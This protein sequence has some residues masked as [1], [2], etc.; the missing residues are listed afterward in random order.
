MLDNCEHV[1]TG[2]APLA[3]ALLANA[4][5]MQVRRRHA[6]C[7]LSHLTEAERAWDSSNTEEWLAR[8]AMLIPDV[9]R[10][11]DWAENHASEAQTG[12]AI[13]AVMARL[14]RE[15]SLRVEG[16]QRIERALRIAGPDTPALIRGQ[17]L[18]G[19]AL[20]RVDN[21]PEI[22]IT[23]LEEAACIYRL[24]GD[25][26]RLTNPMLFLGIE[27][28]KR[29]DIAGAERA[30]EKCRLLLDASAS[31]R[32][33]IFGLELESVIHFYYHRFDEARE[34]L[35]QPLQVYEARGA[36]R[37]IFVTRGNMLEITLVSGDIGAA[38][39]EGLDLARR[40]HGTPHRGVFG[41]ISINRVA[42]LVR[43]RQFAAALAVAR[44]AAP[45]LPGFRPLFVLIDH[46]ALG[47]GLGGNSK[48]GAI[49]KGFTDCAYAARGWQRK[50]VEAFAATQLGTVLDESLAPDKLAGLVKRGAMLTEAAAWSLALIAI[51]AR[52]EVM[53]VAEV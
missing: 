39:T 25:R 8:Y 11:L 31:Q 48:D 38:I 9:H 49:L 2:V 21:E 46:L 23:A 5:K 4:P 37:S 43:G 26:R 15:L 29:G 45:L 1:L 10:C 13:A 22:V 3:E 35:R 6:H 24:I 27:K 47:V 20:M 41:I 40:L 51:E 34:A 16:A 28:F 32:D 50:P 44:E 42:A 17:L 19:L 30:A 12:V 14:W 18:H 7:L 33:I 36:E 52:T 53:A